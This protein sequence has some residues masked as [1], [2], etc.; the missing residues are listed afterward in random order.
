MTDELA[1]AYI[2]P[3]TPNYYVVGSWAC[4]PG[5]SNP[6]ETP[7][8]PPIPCVGVQIIP[9][10]AGAPIVLIFPE[11]TIAEFISQFQEA[12]GKMIRSFPRRG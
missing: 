7:G 8:Q 5:N 1:K 3:T 12:K 9:L 10:N 11:N 2:D 6:D 4:A